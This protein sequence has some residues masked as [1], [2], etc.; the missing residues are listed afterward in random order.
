[1][2]ATRISSDQRRAQA[3]ASGVR[4][5]ADLGMTTTAIQRIADEVGV[6]SSYVFRLFGSTQAFFLAC[7]DE[8]ETRVRGMFRAAAEHAPADPLGA[9]GEGFRDLVTDG[10]ITGLWL[11]ACALARSDE[12][13]AARCRAVV[14][15]ALGEA[16]R[17]SGAPPEEAASFLA[18]GA[19]VMMLQS[20][21]V[22][23]S[24]GSR[25]AVRN[26]QADTAEGDD[27]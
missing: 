25:S 16:E 20:L 12:K 19:L 9:M 26:L 7:V 24:H 6:S 11:Q 1:M 22:D 17:L 23:L 5:F 3:I 14:A 4:V 8:L 27:A 21:R 13:V 2:A 10:V 15:G 18:D